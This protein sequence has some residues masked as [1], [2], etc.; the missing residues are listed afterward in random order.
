MLRHAALGALT[1]LV[2]GCSTLTESNQQQV[3][4]QT[5]LENRPVAGA[6]CILVNGVGKWFVTT[7]GRVTIQKHAGPL[8][9]DCRKDGVGRADELIGSK[10]RGNLWGN[11]L[12]LGVGYLV[13]RDTGAGYDYPA[14]LTIEMKKTGAGASSEGPPAGSVVY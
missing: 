7:P 9:V 2:G 3:M 11:V 14:T 10:A 6:G 8:R 12:T 1:V 4:V 13:D 5:I